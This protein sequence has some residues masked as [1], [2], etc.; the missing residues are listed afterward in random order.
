MYICMYVY[1]ML[2]DGRGA[3]KSRAE[4]ARWLDLAAASG[5]LP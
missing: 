2:A 3:A 1:R 5:R 4:A